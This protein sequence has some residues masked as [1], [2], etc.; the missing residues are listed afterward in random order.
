MT[1]SQSDAR[2]HVLDLMDQGMTGRTIARLCG[3]HESVISKWRTGRR[4]LHPSMLDRIMR[5]APADKHLTESAIESRDEVIEEYEHFHGRLGMSEEDFLRDV[6][7]RIGMSASAAARILDAYH[8]EQSPVGLTPSEVAILVT[9]EGDGM[10]TR[11]EAPLARG[12]EQR[13][14]I[15]TTVWRGKSNARIADLTDEGRR[16]L[17]KER[18]AHACQS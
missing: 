1:I 11:A 13:G 2:R 5:I 18:T 14:L 9:A 7:P 6:V 4:Q 12:L 17:E 10:M 3:V 8:R 16:A 15:T